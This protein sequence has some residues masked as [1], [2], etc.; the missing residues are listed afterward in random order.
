MK[1]T[2]NR[3][4]RDAAVWAVGSSE[5]AVLPDL[6]LDALM[7]GAFSGDIHEG[8]LFKH[9][10]IPDHSLDLLERRSSATK[11]SGVDL[12]EEVEVAPVKTSKGNR[13]RRKSVQTEQ[14]Q[15]PGTP[16]RKT[17]RKAPQG[18]AP[19]LPPPDLIR[20]QS[21][22]LRDVLMATME[23]PGRRPYQKQK[24]SSERARTT[25]RGP[26]SS[27]E[28]PPARRSKR[29]MEERMV[30]EA[31]QQS[32]VE[33][34]KRVVMSSFET[35]IHEVFGRAVYI[36]RAPGIS[37]VEIPQRQEVESAAPQPQQSE[38]IVPHHTEIAPEVPRLSKQ[39]C[40]ERDLQGVLRKLES[41][42]KNLWES[43]RLSLPLA[44]PRLSTSTSSH[45]PSHTS[46]E[47]HQLQQLQAAALEV[48]GVPLHSIDRAPTRMEYFLFNTLPQPPRESLQVWCDTCGLAAAKKLL[49][50][51]PTLLYVPP[52]VMLN[53]LEAI[54]KVLDLAPNACVDTLWSCPSLVGSTEED[55][56]RHLRCLSLALECG[57]QE[58]KEIAT[59]APLVLAMAEEMIEYKCSALVRLLPVPS[60]QLVE[61]ILKRPQLLIQSLKRTGLGVQDLANSLEVDL[62]T[63]GRMVVTNPAV[64]GVANEKLKERCSRLRLLVQA[65]PRWRQ[66]WR[67]L[68]PGG[69]ARCVK[70]SEAALDRL[71]YLVMNH[72]H[73]DAKVED[74]KRVL[75]MSSTRFDQL[76]REL[77]SG[78]PS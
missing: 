1:S 24:G 57:M 6:K 44:L 14:S 15:G 50:R 56:A 35:A 78:V 72:I 23:S 65:N 34:E 7:A 8:D 2:T 67:L 54:N 75:T 64:L 51:E 42:P 4:V 31:L 59:S 22:D 45:H 17:R 21:S 36:P 9:V 28:Q 41:T 10:T 27:T 58:A 12:G 30:L 26:I 19:T 66:Q 46:M 11:T 5:P 55:L 73:Q 43:Q 39:L 62:L 32:Q 49:L 48:L 69:L 13:R 37:S 18:E 16:R 70:A 40:Y 29:R 47:S 20:Q 52:I 71:S 33:E 63:A 3:R 68:S 76:C 25:P 53:T 38:G 60:Y 77:L 61:V 74:F